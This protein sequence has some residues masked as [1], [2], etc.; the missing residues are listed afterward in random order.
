MPVINMVTGIY[1]CVEIDQRGNTSYYSF[2]T[3]TGLLGSV[4]D[5]NG[6][7]IIYGYDTF[8]HLDDLYAVDGD[9]RI[10]FDY[11]DDRLENIRVYDGS[12]YTFSYDSFGRI[13]AIYAGSYV[14]A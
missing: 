14:A 4:T 5:A 12:T 10:F 3:N 6:G 1:F 7:E 13:S 2:N 9:M 8:N 11:T